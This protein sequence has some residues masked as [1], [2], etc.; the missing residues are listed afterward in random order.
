MTLARRSMPLP[1]AVARRTTNPGGWPRRFEAWLGWA[2]LCAWT[3]AWMVAGLL[4]RDAYLARRDHI[5]GLAAENA[6]YP[7]IMIAGFVLTGLL[8]LLMTV[9]FWTAARTNRWAMSAGALMLLVGAGFVAAGLFRSDCAD[10]VTACTIRDQYGATSWHSQ[11]HNVV[12][13][14]LFAFALV[15]LLFTLAIRGQ[16]QTRALR[17]Y[18][19]ATAMLSIALLIVFQFRWWMAWEG[20]VQRAAVT[21]PLLWIA[22]VGAHVGRLRAGIR[23]ALTRRPRFM[24][25]PRADS[26]ARTFLRFYYTARACW[27]R[28]AAV[29][30]RTL[31]RAGR[32]GGRSP[33]RTRLQGGPAATAPAA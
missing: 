13:S 2:A 16:R 4:Q 33:P 31:A 1:Q 23:S 19:L 9:R 29:R 8:L 17:R 12:A 10:A 11:A 6:R 27:L 28:P 15:P 30:R 5:S 32:R 21:L 7:D 18:S 3:S 25:E 22:V 24:G 26:S 14:G 20:V